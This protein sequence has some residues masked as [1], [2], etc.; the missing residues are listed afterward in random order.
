VSVLELSAVSYA[1]PGEPDALRDVTLT[2]EPGEFVV[3]S[4]G[5]GSGKSTLLRAACGLV[6]HFH[7]GIFSGRLR[8]AG[9]DTR[10]RKSTRLNSSHRIQY[11]MPSSA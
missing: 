5:S 4:G 2:V 11:R 10:D 1:Y 3:V 9:L 8:C 6:P 7:G